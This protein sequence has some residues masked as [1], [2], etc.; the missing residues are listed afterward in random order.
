MTANKKYPSIA[1]CAMYLIFH[2]EDW[3]NKKISDEVIFLMNSRTGSGTISWYRGKLKAG[4][5]KIEDYVNSDGTV[6]QKTLSNVN[7]PKEL[8]VTDEDIENA[9]G[10]QKMAFEFHKN[11]SEKTFNELYYRL[12]P[13]LKYHALKIMK[14]EHAA[15]DVVSIAFTKIWSKIEQYN[16]YWNFST[17]AYKIVY[18]EAM[19]HIKRNK[20]LVSAETEETKLNKIQ[21]EEFNEEAVADLFYE[22]AN[23][24]VDNDEDVSE[25]MYAKVIN[26]INN[27]SDSYKTIIL[28]R[29]IN[30]LKYKQISDKHGININSVKTRIKRA[31][32]QIID[33]NQEYKLLV[34]KKKNRK[35]PKKFVKEHEM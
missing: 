10:I 11:R 28:D 27:L 1:H 6:K 12:K 18:N 31:R 13:G 29:E 4:E 16:K 24:N 33:N 35:E 8:I 22:E 21:Q 3:S 30:K 34:E 20:M 25:K 9:S 26:E 32:R 17:W 19:Q 7:I 14:D 2:H 15:D 23:W 5:L